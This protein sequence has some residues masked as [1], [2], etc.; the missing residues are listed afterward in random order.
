MDPKTRKPAA[1]LRHSEGAIPAEGPIPS[2][3]Q[4]KV[5]RRDDALLDEPGPA[6]P[7]PGR[8]RERR[9]GDPWGGD[10]G[11]ER[12]RLKRCHLE[13]RPT[14]E[15]TDGFIDQTAEFRKRKAQLRFGSESLPVEEAALG[16][17]GLRV[18]QHHCRILSSCKQLKYFV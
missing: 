18:A 11:A 4:W 2:Q 15:G 17:P 16:Q 8:T 10:G 5:F 7:V 1:P 6:Q 9:D 13:G 12:F 3:L 14:L